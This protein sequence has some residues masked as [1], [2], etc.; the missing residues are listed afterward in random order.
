[1]ARRFGDIML[2]AQPV[3][4]EQTHYPRPQPASLTRAG[5]W[6]NDNSGVFLL[7]K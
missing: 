6:V 5:G 3:A 4:L 7:Q 2:E 1:V